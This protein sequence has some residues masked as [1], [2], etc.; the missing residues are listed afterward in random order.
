MV[1][2]N[3]NRLFVQRSEQGGWTMMRMLL[4][5]SVVALALVGSYAPRAFAAED[6]VV[7]GTIDTVTPNAIS[8]KAGSQEMKFTVDA[9]T[10]VE[11]TGAGT[12]SRAAQAA[13]RAGAQVTELLKP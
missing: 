9:K 2:N 8:I 13:G 7:R 6:K 12:K 5:G 1:L 10:H 11:A 3:Q 4:A